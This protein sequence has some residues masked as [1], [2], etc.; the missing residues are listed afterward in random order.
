MKEKMQELRK[1]HREAIV[2]KKTI[3]AAWIREEIKE[4][5][6]QAFKKGYTLEQLY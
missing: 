5:A 6:K 2:N 1:E 3:R 4:L